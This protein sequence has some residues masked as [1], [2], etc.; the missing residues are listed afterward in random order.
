MNDEQKRMISWPV[1]ILAI[2]FI[3]LLYG[4]IA[5]P[6]FKTHTYNTAADAR[7]WGHIAD[8]V[9]RDEI[10]DTNGPY[11]FS[12]AMVSGL[13]KPFAFDLRCGGQTIHWSQ[14][15]STNTWFVVT[16]FKNR[17]GNQ[18]AVIRKRTKGN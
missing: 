14:P 8:A 5:L 3:V 2:L 16:V 11:K 13:G 7:V 4:A 10:G 15:A 9:I 18:F 1:R 12:G 17:A 6:C